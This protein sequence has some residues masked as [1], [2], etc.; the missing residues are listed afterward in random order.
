MHLGHRIPL[1]L[2]LPVSLRCPPLGNLHPWSPSPDLSLCQGP[3]CA[4]RQPVYTRAVGIGAVLDFPSTVC[5][6]A[7]VAVL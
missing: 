6:P 3:G 5:A 4:C 1:H 2:P 7:P